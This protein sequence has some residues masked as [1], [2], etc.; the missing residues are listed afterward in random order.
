MS[1]LLDAFQRATA[2]EAELRT[3]SR[4]HWRR[5]RRL[6]AAAAEAAAQADEFRDAAAAGGIVTSTPGFRNVMRTSSLDQRI[7]YALD[8]DLI[9]LEPAMEITGRHRGDPLGI[10]A[11]LDALGVPRDLDA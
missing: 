1:E 2:L 5:R 9:D 10:H 4:L 3:T 7:R 6:E 8:E 11:E